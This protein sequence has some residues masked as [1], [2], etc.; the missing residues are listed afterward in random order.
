M[1]KPTQADPRHRTDEFAQGAFQPH[2][3]VEVWLDGRILRYDAVG[4]FN[5]ELVRAIAK[6]QH[7]IMVAAKAR[8][9]CVEIVTIRE[10]ALVTS[11][12][13]AELAAIL[14]D[15]NHQGLAPLAVAYV[16]APE[17]EG[18]SIMAPVF[19]SRYQS[20]GR[21]FE[22]FD[23]LEDAQTWALGLLGTR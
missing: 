23:R 21:V 19:R 12:G 15:V 14:H 20:Q 9:P 1:N 17:V 10:S 4:P 11:D 18:A 13:L 2:G 7:D 22:L 16:M 6:A 8:G 5:R 3:L